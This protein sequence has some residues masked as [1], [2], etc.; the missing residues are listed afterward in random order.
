[1]NWKGER[2]KWYPYLT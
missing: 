1:M 2:T